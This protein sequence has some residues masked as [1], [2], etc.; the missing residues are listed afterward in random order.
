[1]LAMRT[2]STPVL[3]A[4]SLLLVFCCA[5]IADCHGDCHEDSPDMCGANCSCACTHAIVTPPLVLDSGLV[6]HERH[7]NIDHIALNSDPG[8]V[9]QPPKPLA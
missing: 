7:L 1:M 8:S 5:G 9:F 2:G 4:I 3:I 6:V